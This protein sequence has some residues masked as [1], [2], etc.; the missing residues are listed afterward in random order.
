M[1]GTKRE[2][3]GTRQLYVGWSEAKV[4][5]INPT[6]EEFEKMGIEVEEEPKYSKT[7]KD[8]EVT[9]IDFWMEDLK[10]GYKYKRTF[11]LQDVPAKTKPKE[12]KEDEFVEKTQYVNQ[13]GDATWAENK[14][15]LIANERFI[16]FRKKVKGGEEGEFEVY[17]DKLHRIGKRGEGDLMMFVRQWLAEGNYY[18]VNTNI[19][20]DM[21]KIFN[22]NFKELKEQVGGE[23]ATIIKAGKELP[24]TV[25][26]ILEVK[27]VD[28]EDGIKE[29]QSAWRRS[30]PGWQM[31]SVR[32]TKFTR[33]NIAKWIK[34]GKG[35]NNPAGTRWLKDYEK[36]AIE[37]STGEHK[38]KNFYSLDPIHEYNSEENFV[39]GGEAVTTAK[40]ATTET[41][42]DY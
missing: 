32:N 35:K 4:I 18:D 39:A 5:A 12:G 42:D 20:L 33:E 41:D 40:K 36:L 24:T 29:F 2:S 10:T 28:G 38:S 8:E 37:I 3:T 31:K 16:K 27:V 22:G 6:L 25:L 9:W 26:S 17:G 34:E 14:K 30:C 7:V 1:Q 21:K 23:F 11:F 19:L 15:E 13:V